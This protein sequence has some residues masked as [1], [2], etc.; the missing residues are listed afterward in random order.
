MAKENISL[1]D[2]EFQFHNIGE[3][4]SKTWKQKDVERLLWIYDKVRNKAILFS[5]TFPLAQVTNT[6]QC[7]VAGLANETQVVWCPNF[8]HL[9]CKWEYGDTKIFGTRCKANV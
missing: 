6:Y 5:C 8:L 4:S 2:L 1:A 9:L 7:I 3:R